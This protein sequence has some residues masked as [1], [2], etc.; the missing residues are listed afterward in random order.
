M[1]LVTYRVTL[2]APKQLGW[3]IDSWVV[4]LNLAVCWAAAKGILRDRPRALPR[5]MRELLEDWDAW[6]SLLRTIDGALRDVLFSHG[7]TASQPLPPAEIAPLLRPLSDVRLAPPL[8]PVTLRDFY[9]FEDHV[10]TARARRGLGMVKEW[11]QFPVFYFSNPHA[12]FGHGEPVPKP[13]YTACLDYELEIACVLGKGG[14]DVSVEEAE[15]MIAGYMILNDWSARDVQQ[16]EMKV[17]LGPAKGKD[18]ATSLGPYLV[19]PDELEP[20][21]CGDRYDLEMRAE[22]NGHLYSR[23]NFKDIHYT[24]PEMI[25]RAAQGVRLR[26]GEVFGSGTV[27]TGCILELGPDRYPWLQAGDVVTLS[28]TGLGTLQNRVAETEESPFR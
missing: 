24:F 23:G 7:E 28:V 3:V 11:Y 21:R 22:V 2:Y 20:Y 14:K 12:V 17:G 16:Q 15:R 6:L 4:D 18:F 26:P 8:V 13:P 25:A 5:D 19:T 10:K 27:G 9:A 1:K